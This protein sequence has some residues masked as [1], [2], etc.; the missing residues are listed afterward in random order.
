MKLTLVTDVEQERVLKGGES[1]RAIA[2]ELM[3]QGHDVRIFWTEALHIQ[4]CCG[5]FSCW[6]KTPGKCIFQ[7]DM[8]EIVENYVHSDWVIFLTGISAGFIDSKTKKVLDR[9]IV[10]VLPYIRNFGGECHHLPRYDHSPNLGFFLLDAGLLDAE[11]FAIIR[12]D[13][14]R[15]SLNFHASRLFVA[16]FDAN[17]KEVLYE[18]IAH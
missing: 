9:M 18:N 5:C 1:V 10:T 12:D 4:P 16:R 7:D 15:V 17:A 6:V 13:L 8:E 14:H 3:D 2:S 11:G